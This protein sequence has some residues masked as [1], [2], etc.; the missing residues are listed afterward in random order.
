MFGEKLQGTSGEV[1]T[2]DAL[3]G[4]SGVLVYFSAHWCPPCRGFTPKLA[5]F[6]NKHASTKKFEGIPSLIVLGSDGELITKDGRSKVMEN[7]EDCAG[8]PWKPPSFAEALGDKFLKQDGTAVGKEAI[9][10]KTL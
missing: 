6:Y 5:E 7:F 2:S 9:A 1:K 10:G 3:S 4:K 8:F